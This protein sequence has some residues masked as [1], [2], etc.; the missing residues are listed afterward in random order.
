MRSLEE[1]EHIAEQLICHWYSV[2][3]GMSFSNPNVIN[4]LRNSIIRTIL[5]DPSID[6]LVARKLA[7]DV[8]MGWITECDGLMV[9]SLPV[10]EVLEVRLARVL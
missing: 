6:P 10:M 7:Q 4:Y 5:K 2:T 3:R 8:L 1:K 9:D